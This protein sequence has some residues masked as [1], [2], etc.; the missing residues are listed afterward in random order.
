[1]NGAAFTPVGR[2]YWVPKNGQWE[3]ADCDYEADFL[4]K[5]NAASDNWLVPAIKMLKAIKR[6]YFSDMSSFYLEIIA[7]DLIP[8]IV[9]SYKERNLTLSY[10]GI[11]TEFFAHAPKFMEGSVKML[12]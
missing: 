3:L 8:Q 1:N 2:G 5:Q 10:P 9:S 6:E 7:V 4:T 11:I 12:G